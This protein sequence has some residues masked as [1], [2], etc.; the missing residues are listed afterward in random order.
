MPLNPH[1]PLENRI[2]RFSEVVEKIKNKGK[3]LQ[4]YDKTTTGQTVVHFATKV[5]FRELLAT[6][7]YNLKYNRYYSDFEFDDISQRTVFRIKSDLNTVQIN[8]LRQ[9]IRK[10]KSYLIRVLE[11]S[12]QHQSEKSLPQG[13]INNSLVNIYNYFELLEFK[14]E[15]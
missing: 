2:L 8:E 9:E 15:E 13:M 3:L 10:I 12:R 6:L 7:K 4:S 14:L 1:K 5:L 11:V